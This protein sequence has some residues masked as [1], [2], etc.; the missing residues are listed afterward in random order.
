MMTKP[1]FIILLICLS[2]FRSAGQHP[3]AYYVNWLYEHYFHGE[4]EVVLYGGRADIVND[5]YAIEVERAPNWKNSIG[6]SLWYGMQTNK[7]PGIVLVMENIDQRRYGIMLQSALDYAGIADKITVWF[8]PEDFGLGFSTAQPLIGEMQYSYNTN[9]G[10]R[11]NSNCTY[12][13]CQ[14]C[15]PCDGNRGKACGR[16]G[17]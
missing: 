10:V 15:V 9:S 16:C 3:E 6:Q 11:H 12:F 4:R 17:G 1:V 2:L 5:A 13:S 14:N 7:K 8:Y